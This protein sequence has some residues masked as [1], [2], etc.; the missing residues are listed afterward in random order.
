MFRILVLQFPSPFYVG[1]V[2]DVAFR[3]CGGQE[4]PPVES[5]LVSSTA[6]NDIDGI[7]LVLSGDG[8]A[9]GHFGIFVK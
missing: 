8:A 5:W 3:C 2:P 4:D 7:I 6:E 9:V 1:G